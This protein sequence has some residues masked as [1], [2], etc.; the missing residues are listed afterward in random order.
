LSIVCSLV[1]KFHFG[2]RCI[3]LSLLI[4]HHSQLALLRAQNHRLLAHAPHHVER[5][6]GLAPKR[7]LQHVVGHALLKSLAKLV[8]HLEEALG[9]AQAPDTLMRTAVVVVLHPQ[10]HP[11]HGVV[12][13]VKLRPAQKLL[14]D[15]LPES[16]YLAQRHRV[17]RP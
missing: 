1:F 4:H 5:R 6:L 10:A 3:R 7:H 13:T 12:E 15:A 14:V 11:L 8:L 17:M 2:L 16:L 9:G